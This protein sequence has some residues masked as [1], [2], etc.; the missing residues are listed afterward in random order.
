M[1]KRLAFVTV[2]EIIAGQPAV[3]RT[4]DSWCVSMVFGTA[5]YVLWVSREINVFLCAP[6]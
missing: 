2:V 3:G 4:L 1:C 6:E 5:S